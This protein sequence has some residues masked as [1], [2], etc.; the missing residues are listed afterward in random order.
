MG[1]GISNDSVLLY[2]NCFVKSMLYR[3]YMPVFKPNV[4]HFFTL[5]VNSI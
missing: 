2:M 4:F 5:F 3:N 1:G